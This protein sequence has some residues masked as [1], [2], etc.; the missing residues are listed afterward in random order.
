MKVTIITVVYNRVNTIGQTLASVQSQDYNNIEHIIQDGGSTDGTKLIIARNLNHQ[1]FFCSEADEGVYDA[2]NKAIMRS[3]GDVIGILHSDDFFASTNI[4]SCVAEI[5]AEMS[6]D[7]LYGDI[8]YVS[9]D[10]IN[11]VVRYWS[12]GA[13]NVNLLNGGW[14]PPHP[15]VFLRRSVFD[16]FGLYDTSYKISADYEA[17]LRY[18]KN[19][20]IKL[21]YLPYVLTRMRTG[22]LSNQ[23]LRHIIQK[24][25]EDYRALKSN[26]YKPFVALIKKNLS[27]LPQFIRR[28]SKCRKKKP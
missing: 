3:T 27:K 23:S 5:F 17:L 20:N 15:T 16:T 7:G 14:M 2:L 22:G 8:E 13:Y 9:T 28:R 24:S 21:F 11:R 19:N 12:A 26:G 10:N 25:Y 4:I 1:S 6:I 18:L